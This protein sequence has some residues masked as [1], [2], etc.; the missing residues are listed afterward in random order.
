[1]WRQLHEMPPITFGVHPAEG[2]NPI[3]LVQGSSKQKKN[4]NKK[5]TQESWL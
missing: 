4:K 5:K 2:R 3:A 1:M